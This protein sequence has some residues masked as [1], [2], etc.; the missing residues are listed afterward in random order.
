[1]TSRCVYDSRGASSAFSCSSVYQRVRLCTP[2]AL[3]SYEHVRT[4]IL[5]YA[6][7]ACPPTRRRDQ[8]LAAGIVS[9][10]CCRIQG[11]SLCMYWYRLY[12]HVVVEHLLCTRYC[13]TAST[14]QRV[15]PAQ[16]KQIKYVPVR[17]RHRKRR[18]SNA[19]QSRKH[20]TAQRNQPAQSCKAS[21][22][23]S[24]CEIRAQKPQAGRQSWRASS[25]RR[26]FISRAEFSKPTKK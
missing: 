2:L 18:T 13:G 6:T 17:V 16:K 15:Q 1:M 21:T 11:S 24:G 25:C 8:Q 7:D 10:T 3:L 19:L 26:A 14:P 22:C 12:E 4:R 20:S 5:S 23:R 9:G